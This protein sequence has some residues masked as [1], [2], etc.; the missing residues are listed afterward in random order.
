MNDKNEP[1]VREDGTYATTPLRKEMI[2]AA[3]VQTRV[4]GVNGENPGPDIR[5]NLDYF[6]ECID[7]AQGY[8]P[9]NDLLLFHEFP[10]TGFSE[11]TKEQ[12][13]NLAIEVP[14]PETEEVGKKAKKHGC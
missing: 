6:L 11:W 2:S 9:P 3:V 1:M 5:R 7:I 4:G 10:I 12:H 8:G 14:G 13:Y